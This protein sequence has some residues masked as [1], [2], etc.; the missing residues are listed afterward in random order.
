M[1]LHIFKVSLDDFTTPSSIEN[2]CALLE[3]C[4]RYLL[5]GDATRERM[6]IMLDVFKRKKAV[7]NVDSRHLTMLENAY[8][9]CDPPDR[10]AVAPKQRTP[11]HLFIHHLMYGILAKPTIDEVYR[12]L[13]KLHWNRPEVSLQ[14]RHLPSLSLI[15]HARQTVHRLY[16][17][18]TK[19]WKAKFSNIY[20]FAMLLHDLARHH[21]DFC[22]SVIDGILENI[23][24][25]MERNI[26]KYNQRR[27]ATLKFLGELYVYRMVDARIILDTL[28]SITTFGHRK[29]SLALMAS[30]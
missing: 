28:W 6:T 9:Q 19:V 7:Q 11:T 29:Y 15:V 27:I 25:G 17:A 24:A 18:F 14:Q 20:L 22:V 10:V 16:N 4:G 8:Y 1:A 30:Y 21:S 3:G 5:R 13:R 2:M 12:L 23:T 26:F